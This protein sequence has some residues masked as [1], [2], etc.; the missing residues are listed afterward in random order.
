MIIGIAT[1]QPGMRP[2]ADIARAAECITAS[3]AEGAGLGLAIVKSI[4]GLHNGD[5]TAQSVIGKG[6]SVRLFFPAKALP[7]VDKPNI[8][9]ARASTSLA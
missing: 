8:I 6:T 2:L 4:T 7:S 3:Q 9:R 5:I 1:A